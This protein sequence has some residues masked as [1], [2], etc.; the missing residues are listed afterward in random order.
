MTQPVGS[1][2]RLPPPLAAI[3]GR[4]PQWPLSAA[5]AAGLNVLLVPLL[6]ADARAMLRDRVVSIQVA[7]AGLDCRVRL[8]STGFVPARTPA[9]VV[10]RASAYDY[11]RLARRVDDPDTLFFARRLLIEG[12]TELGLAV[13]NALDAVEWSPAA[14]LAAICRRATAAG[15]R[16]GRASAR[17]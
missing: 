3:A 5:L 2:P 8:G 12:D 6:G 16:S 1:S 9:E 4:L 17:P 7:D 13:K 10:I 11:W 15:G 14:V